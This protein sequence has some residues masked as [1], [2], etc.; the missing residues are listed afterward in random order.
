MKRILMA[1]AAMAVLGGL[2][3]GVAATTASAATTPASAN[4]A[5]GMTPEVVLVNQPASRVCVGSRFTVGAWYQ[6]FSGGSRAYRIAV[7][8]P[9]G[10][11]V[12]WTKGYASSTAWRLWHISAWRKGNFRTVYHTKNSSGQWIKYV[13]NTWSHYC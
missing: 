2:A 1:V 12:F 10:W 9:K 8:N 11:L 3:P 4:S 13:A 5:P 7:Y 6:S